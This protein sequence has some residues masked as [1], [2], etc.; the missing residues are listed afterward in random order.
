M[1]VSHTHFRDEQEIAP[2]DVYSAVANFTSLLLEGNSKWVSKLIKNMPSI[3]NAKAV[4]CQN[5]R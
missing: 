5:G 1:W 2:V 3:V 4:R